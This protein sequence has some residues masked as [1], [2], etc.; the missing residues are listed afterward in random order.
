MNMKIVEKS[1][2]LSRLMRRRVRLRS[3][4]E[5]AVPSQ[6]WFWSRRHKSERNTTMP[7]I[8]I[9]FDD[10]DTMP[11]RLR[12]R[13]D[14]WGISTEAMIHRAINSFMGDYGLKS[15]P[16]GFEA[17]NLR[18]FFHAHGVMKTDSK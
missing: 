9:N 1:P 11:D 14:E 10:D 4:S 18:E 6:Q 15:P 5:R 16:P 2:R 13:A 12:E 8:V 7:Q 17:K 3:R